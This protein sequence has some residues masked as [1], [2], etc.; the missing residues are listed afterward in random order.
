MGAG[1]WLA[2]AEERR[3]QLQGKR[4]GEKE[5][6]KKKRKRERGESRSC[7]LILISQFILYFNIGVNDF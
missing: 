2:T 5:T 1:D 4:R 3:T 6:R 7:H